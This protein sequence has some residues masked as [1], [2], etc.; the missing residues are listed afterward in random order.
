MLP[1]QTS[2]EVKVAFLATSYT[3]GVSCTVVVTGERNNLSDDGS[4]YLHSQFLQKQ[5]K[6]GHTYVH[7]Y[8]MCVCVCVWYVCVV[9]VC[10]CAGVG[11]CVG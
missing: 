2:M 5:Y 4:C 3:R 1:L 8:I 9:C 7:A 11:V 10:K 6:M